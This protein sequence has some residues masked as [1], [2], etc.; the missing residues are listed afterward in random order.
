[1]A[2]RLAHTLLVDGVKIYS[3]KAPEVKTCGLVPFG[4]L[5]VDCGVSE[6]YPA[7]AMAVGHP[8]LEL[9]EKNALSGDMVR[10]DAWEL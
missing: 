2:V 10:V 9:Q 6:A 3:A 7:Q 4:R 8:R 1:M 5:L